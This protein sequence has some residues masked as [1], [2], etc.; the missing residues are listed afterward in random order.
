MPE[1]MLIY[2]E[3]SLFLG[4]L[5]YSQI[6]AIVLCLSSLS[7]ATTPQINFDLI[8]SAMLAY[9]CNYTAIWNSQYVAHRAQLMLLAMEGG[10]I[11]W[12]STYN[13]KTLIMI[14]GHLTPHRFN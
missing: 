7:N 11:P 1:G 6:Q 2:T 4:G 13:Y 12:D 3:G 5:W 10:G 9:G 14:H 8:F